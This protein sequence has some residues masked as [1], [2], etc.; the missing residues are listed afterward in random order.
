ML[1]QASQSLGT[2][3][4]VGPVQTS[5][6]T[7]ELD[8]DASMTT[9]KKIKA[10]RGF[11]EQ[12]FNRLIFIIPKLIKGCSAEQETMYLYAFDL[13]LLCYFAKQQRYCPGC[14]YNHLHVLIWG[15]ILKPIFVSK[16]T[17]RFSGT[18]KLIVGT[19]AIATVVQ[20]VE[21]ISQL[22]CFFTTDSETPWHKQ[23]LG[24][25]INNAL[26]AAGV[27]SN[28]MQTLV[29]VVATVT[30]CCFGMVTCLQFYLSALLAFFLRQAKSNLRTQQ[31]HL[32]QGVDQ[33]GVLQK[34]G[35][36][37]SSQYS[38]DSVNQRNVENAEREVESLSSAGGKKY[39]GFSIPDLGSN[40]GTGMYRFWALIW[41]SLEDSPFTLL[42]LI[43]KS[44]LRLC[45]KQGQQLPHLHPAGIVAEEGE[46]D[47][48]IQRSMQPGPDGMA[49]IGIL[50]TSYPGSRM[51]KHERSYVF[52]AHPPPPLPLFLLAQ[53]PT[54]ASRGVQH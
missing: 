14:L 20:V 42:T 37:F 32:R 21:A 23:P 53:R 44:L 41:E 36:V 51:Y 22:Y 49:G 54:N 45:S 27:L 6:S 40:A 9:C 1:I 4:S 30:F 25:I 50:L 43:R 34:V 48:Q 3:H 15:K 47:I 31:S 18:K 5:E 26:K 16:R 39:C 8:E 12:V 11:A 33:R 46:R 13:V 17:R 7:Q 10:V 28:S 29:A 19:S 52:Y 24:E 35:G 2:S 38:K